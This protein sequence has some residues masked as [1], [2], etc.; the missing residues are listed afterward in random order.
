MHSSSMGVL[1]PTPAMK[2]PAPVYY[3]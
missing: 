1:S 2:A 3:A